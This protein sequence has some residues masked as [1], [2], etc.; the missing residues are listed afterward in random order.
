MPWDY[1]THQA[2]KLDFQKKKKKKKEKKILGFIGKKRPSD[3]HLC[4]NA[5][6]T[7]IFYNSENQKITIYMDTFH[8]SNFFPPDRRSEKIQVV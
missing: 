6:V 2:E 4:I 1:V 8:N 7:L 5:K 3:A